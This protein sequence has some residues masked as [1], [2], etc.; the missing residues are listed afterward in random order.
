M[1]PL[2]F[3]E[4]SYKVVWLL[5]VWLPL[6]LA[7]STNGLRLGTLDLD[8]ATALFV[9]VVVGLLVTIPWPYVVTRFVRARGDRWK[10]TA[11]TPIPHSPQPSV[12]RRVRT[13]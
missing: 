3:L 11:G 1:L 6:R 10:G 2:L 4:L 9:A 12:R 5:A 13:G 8:V 7:G